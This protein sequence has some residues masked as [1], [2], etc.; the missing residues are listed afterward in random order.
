MRVLEIR[1]DQVIEVGL[2]RRLAQRVLVGANVDRREPLL[3]VRLEQDPEMW[4]GR[5]LGGRDRMNLAAQA[6]I[7][8]VGQKALP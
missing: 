3:A 2:A 5:R 6:L 1:V 4:I 7:V 8:D